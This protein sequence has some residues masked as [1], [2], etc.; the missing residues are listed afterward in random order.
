M[1]LLAV[2]L[3][4]A[5]FSRPGV[6]RLKS[7]ITRSISV[8]L[9]R[10]VE[11]GSVSLR[12]LPAPGF[13]L[14]NFI[15]YDDQAFGAEPMMQASEVTAELRVASLLRGRLEIARLNLTE[16]SVN[17]VRNGE[18][19]WNLESLLERAANSPM[20]PTGKS[21]RES[22]AGFP[23]VQADG[24]RINLKIGQEKKNYALTNTDF[25]FWQEAENTWAMRLRAQPMR[26]DFNVSDSGDLK[27]N[28]SWQRSSNLR[29][30]PIEFTMQWSGAQLGQL[31]KLVYGK[32]KGWR[33]S[34]KIAATLSGTPGDLT[35]AAD[36]SVQDFRRY[37]IPGGDALRLQASCRGHYSTA[38]KD[39]KEFSCRA[40]VGDGALTLVGELNGLPSLETYDLRIGAQNV[41]VQSISR[42]LSHAKK[43][44]PQ[45]LTAAGRLTADIRLKR[46]L[47]GASWSGGGEALAFKLTSQTNDTSL[48]LNR[49][50]FSLSSDATAE[51]HPENRIDVGPFAIALGRPTPTVVRGWLS[52]SGYDFS[53]Q[54]DT[55]VKK[56]LQL[57]R[58][59]GVPTP[60]VA[61]DG[62]AKVDLTLAGGWSAFK[63]PVV[64]GKAVL[65]SV[66]G[67]VRGMNAPI[68]I[69][70][71]TVVLTPNN[72]NVL[73]L[74]AS[75]GNMQ[76]K[77][78]LAMPRPCAPPDACPLHFDLRVDRLGIDEL[79][80]IL[81]PDTQK[82]PWY[83]FLSSNPQGRSPYL[84][85]LQASGKIAANRL[86]IHG[87]AASHIS[88]DVEVNKGKVLVSDIHA[89]FL[90]GKHVGEWRADFAGKIP[91][92]AGQGTLDRAMLA[93]LGDAMHAPWI[94]GTA[95]LDYQLTTSGQS[96]SD[97]YASANA[98][99][100]VE[101]HDLALTKVMLPNGLNALR[102]HTLTTHMVLKEGLFDFQ[103]GKLDSSRGIYQLSGTASLGRVLDLKLAR[104]NVPTFVVS[105]TLTDP[106]VRPAVN[107]ETRA[108]LKP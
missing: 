90:G 86:D 32:D 23:Y 57:A 103:E 95:N 40:P 67:E 66:R 50:P 25:S 35:F 38:E 81:G 64:N 98:S 52:P 39:L 71:G 76:W 59:I 48:S 46:D 2:I 92:Y 11:I 55:Q 47:D 97:L 33:G 53:I 27:V 65:R 5:L 93:Q 30:T 61:A 9:Q 104:D 80:Q 107:A 100:R 7:R 3:F 31:S 44:M 72:I 10:P 83:K 69:A 91:E 96:L 102:I 17:L 24:G 73:Y 42:L 84:M 78:A 63:A 43:D 16:P 62:S 77:G 87:I 106:K 22:R 1:A 58:T 26:T 82:R 4:L 101:A 79:S 105:G 94:N 45:D 21:K 70:T 36:S 88:G 20:A 6:N 89:D 29:D 54:G 85:T 15:L 108:A 37:D 56:L 12:V 41:P 74:A 60:H 68:E 8:E 49:V 28:G 13:D 34:L 18:G 19:H 99:L 14:K 75:I 51:G